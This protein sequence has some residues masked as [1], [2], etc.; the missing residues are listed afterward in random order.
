CATVGVPVLTLKMSTTEKAPVACSFAC[1]SL[2]QVAVLGAPATSTRMAPVHTPLLH[3]GMF[4]GQ[5]LLQAPQFFASPAK[6]ASQPL[7][8]CLSQSPKLP[9]HEVTVQA[10]AA[11]PLLAFGSV[12][13]WPQAPQFFPSVA[14]VASQPLPALP[15]QSPKPWLHAPSPHAPFLHPAA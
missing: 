12:Q 4:I 13:P 1:T 2:F 15:S 11:Q 10:P 5:T 7:A 9:L 3:A 14:R 8:A 6:L